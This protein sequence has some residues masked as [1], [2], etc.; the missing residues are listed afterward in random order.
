MEYCFKFWS[1]SLNQICYT[2]ISA[3]HLHLILL[4]TCY[5]KIDFEVK[6]NLIQKN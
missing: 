2:T 3:S 4:K 5:I 6:I 1:K